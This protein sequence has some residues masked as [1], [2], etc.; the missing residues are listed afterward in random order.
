M[1]YI[2]LGCVSNVGCTYILYHL[3]ASEI[4]EIL[5]NQW[6]EW[7]SKHWDSPH[8]DVPCCSPSHLIPMVPMGRSKGDVRRWSIIFRSGR[9]ADFQEN[10]RA[11]Q[12]P[13]ILQRFDQ[14]SG[15]PI[16]GHRKDQPHSDMGSEQFLTVL[17]FGGTLILMDPGLPYVAMICNCPGS[18]SMSWSLVKSMVNPKTVLREN[19]FVMHLP[20]KPPSNGTLRF[21]QIPGVLLRVNFLQGQRPSDLQFSWESWLPAATPHMPWSKPGIF[22]YAEIKM[23]QCTSYFRYG[24]NKRKQGFWQIAILK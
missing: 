21:L 23:Y 4:H 11:T 15:R 10:S 3:V 5:I 16:Y 22:P 12:E 20:S 7:G 17:H 9:A 13:R 18:S 2:L 14:D 24:M 1:G 19:R 6:M 8:L